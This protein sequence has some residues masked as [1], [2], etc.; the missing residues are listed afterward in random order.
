MSALEKSWNLKTQ[1]IHQSNSI[2]KKRVLN[3]RGFQR[4]KKYPEKIFYK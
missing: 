3:F 1:P 2:P 4:A